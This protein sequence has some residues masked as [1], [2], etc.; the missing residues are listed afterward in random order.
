MKKLLTMS[1][2]IAAMLVPVAAFAEPFTANGADPSVQPVP[3]DYWA[4]RDAVGSVSVSPDGR[5]MVVQKIESLKGN[6]VIEI[7]DTS[8]LS[9]APKRL[10]TKPMELLNIDR[11]VSDD[12]FF[13]TAMQVVR[14]NM[15]GPEQDVREYK[16]F[17][18]SISNDKFTEFS[19]PDGRGVF[20]LASVLPKEP[21]FILVGTSNGPA[22]AASDDPFEG[23]RPRSYYKLNLKNGR[24]NLVYRGGGKQPQASFDIDGNPR[25][26]S[27]VDIVTDEFISYYRGKND[28]DWREFLR[29]GSRE[30]ERLSFNFVGD[31]P[32]GAEGTGYV[33][34]RP[35]GEDKIGL[36]EYDFNTSTFLRKVYSNPD[37]DVVGTFGSTQF[38]AGDDSIAGV[39]FPGAKNERHFLNKDEE[40]LYNTVKANVPNAFQM[41]ISSRSRDGNT[42]IVSNSAPSDS[43]TFYLLKDGKLRKIGSRNPLLKQED[44]SPV[45]YRTITARDGLEIP[46]YITKPKGPG[47]HPLVVLP[48]G[49]PYI[50]EVI[51]YDEWSQM[52]AN[53]GYMV[54]QPQYRGSTGHGFN[55]YIKMWH[56]H[57]KAMSDDNDD[58]ALQLIKEGKVDKDRVAMFGWSYGGYAALVAATRQ[59]GLYQC[60]IPGAFVADALKQYLGRRDDTI[61]YFD[62]LSAQRGGKVGI[63]PINELDK[64]AVPMLLIHPEWDRRVPFYHFTD[65]KRKLQKLGKDSM[66][67]FLPL[68]GADHFLY[69][70]TYD[71]N[72]TYYTAILDYLKND[73]GPGGL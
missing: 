20:E 46:V 65:T 68:K 1:C 15:K 73:C 38:W 49:G 43:G 21:D 24:R 33:T 26:S 6:P 10:S 41:S 23:F 17:A 36:Y 71:H 48:H 39:I 54:A 34:A 31:I 5:H 61:K 29:V 69:T 11:W 50:T 27:G 13:A 14:R 57:G 60:T 7:Y 4:V 19:T 63:N 72:K 51:V 44:Y 35:E 70:H 52:L 45:E 64:L 37:A 28:K 62:E 53:N 47:P 22:A 30:F 12:I 8:D 59:D 9:K 58:V 42:M 25:F 2:A 56:E 32:G 67:K 55:H 66:V 40:A 18:Y 3:I 16:T